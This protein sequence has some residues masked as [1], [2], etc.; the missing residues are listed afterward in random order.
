MANYTG[1]VRFNDGT[2]LFFSY[3]GTTDIARRRLYER[4]NEVSHA[5]ELIGLPVRV[6]DKEE[7]EVMPYYMHDNKEIAF[8]TQAS[9]GLMAITGPVS[10]DDVIQASAASAHDKWTSPA[11]E[12]D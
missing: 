1:A 6:V 12:I 3:S 5:H 2:I 10:L 8:Y 9:R 11:R 4:P 7:V